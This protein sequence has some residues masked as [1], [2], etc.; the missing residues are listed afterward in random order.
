MST[1]NAPSE[2]AYS[3]AGGARRRLSPPQAASGASGP[4]SAVAVFAKPG[5]AVQR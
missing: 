5:A 3:T 1:H 2:I 4:N